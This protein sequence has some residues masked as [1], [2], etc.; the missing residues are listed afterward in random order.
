MSPAEVLRAARAK[1]EDPSRWLKG[2]YACDDGGFTIFEHSV[3]ATSWCAV[4]AV[5]A[6]VSPT[7]PEWWEATAYLRGQVSSRFCSVQLFNDH[8]KTTHADVMRVFDRAI[9]QAEGTP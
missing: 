5:G 7:S 9:E 6:I 4:G 8:E 2:R 1:I 3:Y